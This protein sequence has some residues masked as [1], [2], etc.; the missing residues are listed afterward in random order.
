LLC[1]AIKNPDDEFRANVDFVTDP[2]YAGLQAGELP[3][4]FSSDSHQTF[5]FIIDRIALSH[6]EHPI[7]V[8][9]LRGDSGR[10]FR[11]IPS[12]IGLVENNLSIANMDFA[13]FADAA[14]PDGVFRG[15]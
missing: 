4:L 15:F 12:A 10:T 13:E 7:L 1:A 2:Q 3:S 5:A 8:V 14:D 9:G 6:P 11:V